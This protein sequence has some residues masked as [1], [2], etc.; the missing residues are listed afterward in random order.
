MKI[1]EIRKA[2]QSD[3]IRIKKL[4]EEERSTIG[5]LTRETYLDAIISGNI[6]VV[7]IDG[8]V[9][10]FQ[11]YYHRKRDLQTTLYQKTIDKKFRN[12]GYAK[13]LVDAVIQEARSIGHKIL[14]LKC[15]EK[16]DS[17]E[18]HKKIGFVLIGQDLGRKQK[19]NIWEMKL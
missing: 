5:F 15:P 10:G 4:A 9:I 7:T 2:V 1:V 12:N 11:F 13:L 3:I 18:F 14:V 6:F 8:F 17:N 19:L 16:L